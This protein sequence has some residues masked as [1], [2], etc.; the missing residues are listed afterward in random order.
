MSKKKQMKTKE[1][2]I[3]KSTQVPKDA[4]LKV[5]KVILAVAIAVIFALFIGFG[6]NVFY[7]EPEYDDF[8]NVEAKRVL[9]TSTACEESGGKWTFY[10]HEVP[11]NI[12][13]DELVTG[14]CNLQYYCRQEWEKARGGYNRILFIVTA[15]IGILTIFISIVLKLPS[16]SSGL[17][18]GGVLVIIYGILRYW[19]Y[20]TDFLRFV[21]L[22]V[23]LGILI[24]LGYKK[25]NK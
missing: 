5:K 16:V 10:E 11:R 7:P 4:G 15:I 25:L 18:A 22:G 17:M 8:C 20:S 21:I 19:R 12:D 2:I 13:T 6:I 23:V 1:K 24:W 9:N 14:Y 3:K